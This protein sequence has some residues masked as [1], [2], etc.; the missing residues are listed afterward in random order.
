MWTILSAVGILIATYL[1]LFLGWHIPN[2]LVEKGRPPYYM[3]VLSILY[4]VIALMALWDLFTRRYSLDMYALIFEISSITLGMVYI[5][6]IRSRYNGNDVSIV[7]RWLY[8]ISFG[9]FI[10]SMMYAITSHMLISTING[11]FAGIMGILP[12]PHWIDKILTP[13]SK[14]S[15]AWYAVLHKFSK[16][17]KDE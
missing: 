12:I 1:L 14:E 4:G 9:T 6:A 17:R 5:Y 15:T 2:H 13:P 3:L 16:P 8:A 11:V 7:V 10:F